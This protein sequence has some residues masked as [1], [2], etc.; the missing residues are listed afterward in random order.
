MHLN[1]LALLAPSEGQLAH[2]QQCTECQSR[3]DNLQKVNAQLNALPELAPSELS[4]QRIQKTLK[5]NEV[6]EDAK[7]PIFL[8]WKISA[9]VAACLGFMVLAGYQYVL[10]SSLSKTQFELENVIA[11]N[12][13]LYLQLENMRSSETAYDIQLAKIDYLINQLDNKLQQA[14][15]ENQSEQQIL[16]LWQTRQA[17]LNE[18]EQ[19]SVNNQI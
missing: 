18:I 11:Q 13:Q 7:S 9:R 2:L 17:L 12:E 19:F 6:V 4:W 10:H 5:Q 16:Q 3:L 14:Y 8:N 1:D 15:L